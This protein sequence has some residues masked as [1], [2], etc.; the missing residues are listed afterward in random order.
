MNYIFNSSLEN[1]FKMIKINS[2]FLQWTLYN[3]ATIDCEAHTNWLVYES[4]LENDDCSRTQYLTDCLRR[5][6]KPTF[7]NT[8]ISGKNPQLAGFLVTQNC[9]LNLSIESSIAWHYDYLHHL[10][11]IYIAEERYDK[12]PCYLP[13]HRYVSWPHSLTNFFNAN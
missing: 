10:T 4:C 7:T 6:K 11:P 3:T 2:S 9:S 8:P 13:W 5:P 12:I 1:S